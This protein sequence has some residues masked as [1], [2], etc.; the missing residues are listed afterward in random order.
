MRNVTIRTN[1]QQEA[2]RRLLRGL[3]SASLSPLG[4]RL[5]AD[6]LAFSVGVNDHLLQT[7]TKFGQTTDVRCVVAGLPRTGSTL[8]HNLLGLHP[9]LRVLSGAEAV[10]PLNPSGVERARARRLWAVR[11][12]PAIDVLHKPAVLE[13]EECNVLATH[14]FQSWQYVVYASMPDY[15]RWL[16]DEPQPDVLF[17]E[18]AALAKIEVSG[19]WVI[20]SPFHS[21]HVRQMADVWPR[22][23]F[24]EIVRD[25]S[26]VDLS[27]RRLVTA[28]RKVYAER[29]PEDE[30]LW[31]ATWDE[32]ERR[33]TEC[34]AEFP[35]RF[36][37]YSYGQLLDDPMSVCEDVVGRLGLES[38]DDYKRA[39][40]DFVRRDPLRTPSKERE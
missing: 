34:S 9:A 21:L 38:D 2:L 10:A 39:V 14:S 30:D 11:L 27:W 8:L 32:A 36:L 31:R 18:D 15:H 19:R 23:M 7:S 25:R 13:A 37:R 4:Y 5:L 33:L 16:L 22:A 24:V 12:S 26:Q 40:E 35:D 6:D 28:A 20:K 17:W 1:W 3:E 29:P